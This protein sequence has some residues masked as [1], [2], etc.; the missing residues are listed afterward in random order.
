MPQGQIK[1]KSKNKW[2]KTQRILDIQ[3]MNTYDLNSDHQNSPLDDVKP[4]RQ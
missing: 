4:N 3:Y 1:N 2:T